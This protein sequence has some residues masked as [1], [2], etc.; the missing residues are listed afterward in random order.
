MIPAKSPGAQKRVSLL[1]AVAVMAAAMTAGGAAMWYLSPTADQVSETVPF[2][3]RIFLPEGERLAS[4]YRHAVALSP[5]GRQSPRGNDWRLFID[6]L[7]PSHR[8]AGNWPSSRERSLMV[9]SARWIRKST[10]TIWI[11]G[12]PG[13]SPARRTRCNPFSLRMATGWVS[14]RGENSGR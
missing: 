4:F 10:C 2:R 1:W 9:P 14:L 3:N 5:D 12:S 11:S 8:T 13:P 7:W 6:T